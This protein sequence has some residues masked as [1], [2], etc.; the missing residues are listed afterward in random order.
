M[1]KSCQQDEVLLIPYEGSPNFLFPQEKNISAFC[2]NNEMR[3]LLD[4]PYNPEKSILDY[5]HL[6]KMDTPETL[7]SIRL[8]ESQLHEFFDFNKLDQYGEVFHS[9]KL[10]QR[11]QLL[12]QMI[13]RI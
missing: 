8:N 10:Q 7:G 4:R 6:N 12:K 2:P 3:L 11:I 1:I 13:Q 5:L 9:K